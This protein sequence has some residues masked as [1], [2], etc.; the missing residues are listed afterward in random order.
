MNPQL[1][2]KVAVVNSG[3]VIKILPVP[4]AVGPGDS[5]VLLDLSA[6]VVVGNLYDGKGF[7][8]DPQAA[9]LAAVEQKKK[10]IAALLAAA[11]TDAE[12]KAVVAAVDTD[13]NPK[14]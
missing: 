9:E 10:D 6:A 8:P 7:S 4:G 1:A 13:V 5:L 14:P 2:A 11:K 3:K 12:L